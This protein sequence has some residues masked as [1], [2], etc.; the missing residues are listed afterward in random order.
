MKI[1]QNLCC[2]LL[3]A[4]AAHL[5]AEALVKPLPTPDTSKL[6]PDVAKQLTQARAEF[7]KE[8]V[9][10]ES[11]TLAVAYAQMGALYFRAGLLDIADIAFYDATQLA[12]N[13]ARWIYLRGVLARAQKRKADARANF[14]AALPLDQDYLP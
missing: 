5:H 7:D 9:N 14:E 1:L 2:L 13:D 4:G 11:D 3:V 10:L 12:P 6:T 8:K